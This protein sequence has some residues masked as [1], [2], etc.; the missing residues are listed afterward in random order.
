VI[1]KKNNVPNPGLVG[2]ETALA[3][4]GRRIASFTPYRPEATAAERAE[5]APY[6][7]N[8]AARIE[9]ALQRPGPGVDIWDIRLNRDP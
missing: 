6:L 4:E 3:R 8:T 2:L 1:L 7:H 5:V 9:H